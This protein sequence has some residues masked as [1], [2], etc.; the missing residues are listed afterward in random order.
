MMIT[1]RSAIF[2]V[3]Y[4][5][6]GILYGMTSIFIFFLPPIVRHRYLVSWCWLMIR[7]LRLSCGVKF[8]II[9]HE[10]L[11]KTKSP[12]VILSK[13]QSTWETL[14]LQ[15]LCCPAST[16][17]KRELLKIP[18]FG[19][20]LRLLQP[21]GIDRD[22]PR[23]ALKQVKSEGVDRLQKG[24][25]LLLYPEGTRMA[26]GERG[27]YARS[28]ADIALEAGAD[29]IP[30]AVN[31]GYCWPAKG[32]R[33]YPGEVTLIFGEPIVAAGRNSKELITQVED[34]IENQLNI[35]GSSVK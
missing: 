18:F 10:N 14:A 32:I 16:I 23:E 26:P 4:F 31:A 27:K 35:M 30:V 5:S 12:K 33:I 17:L 21:I 19:W 2:N 25:N 7:W 3:V 1:F 24:L 8:K 20:G 34:W 6:T 11:V 22:N 29:I 9:G 13:H 28:G 15:Y